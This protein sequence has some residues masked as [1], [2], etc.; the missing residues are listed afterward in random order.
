MMKK[1]LAVLLPVLVAVSITMGYNNGLTTQSAIF[2]G[3]T[4]SGIS[5][6]S[7]SSKVE[8][9]HLIKRHSALFSLGDPDTGGESN[10]YRWY[11][12]LGNSGLD[13]LI[14]LAKFSLNNIGIRYWR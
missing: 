5:D 2:R 6:R 13:A 14:F 7:K 11:V 1:I 4:L 12:D 3:K 8:T 9:N 10:F